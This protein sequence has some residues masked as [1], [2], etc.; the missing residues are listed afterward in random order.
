MA[1]PVVKK[2]TPMGKLS[3]ATRTNISQ[4]NRKNMPDSWFLGPN[5]T[6]PY[7]VDGKIRCDLLDAAIHRAAQQKE[8]GIETKARVL[9]QQHCGGA[10]QTTPTKP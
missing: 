9:Y 7:I 3:Q 2:S 4:S 5:K 1:K 10:Q 6:Y 8:V